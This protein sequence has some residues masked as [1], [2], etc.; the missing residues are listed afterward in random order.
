MQHPQTSQLSQKNVEDPL[1]QPRQRQQQQQ[2]QQ[3]P[4]QHQ[5]NDQPKELTKRLPQ[6]MKGFEQNSQVVVRNSSLPHAK[7]SSVNVNINFNY[8]G[9]FETEESV[10]DLGIYSDNKDKASI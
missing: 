7:M 9:N 4:R 3:Q 8:Y 5:Q 1:K 6:N 2:Q 10:A